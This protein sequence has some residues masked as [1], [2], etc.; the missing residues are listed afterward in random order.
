MMIVE[1]YNA[2]IRSVSGIMN[3]AAVIWV[4]WRC[5]KCCGDIRGVVG[6]DIAAYEWGWWR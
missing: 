2:Y 3:T 6:V 5:W 1:W 4:R